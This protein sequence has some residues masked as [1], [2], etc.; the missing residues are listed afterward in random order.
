MAERILHVIG[1]MDRGGAE[2]FIMNLYRAVDRERI[3]FDFLVHEQ[4]LC[5]YDEEISDLGGRLYRLPRYNGLNYGAYRSQC[6]AFFARVSE[7]AVVHGHIGS[8]A[9]IY[10]SEARRAGRYTIAHSHAQNYEPGLSGLAFRIASAPVKNI[11]DYFMACSREAGVD[12]FGERIV[13][14]GRFRI[15]P[16]GVDLEALRFDADERSRMRKELGLG[17]EPVFGHV[18]RLTEVKNHAFLLQVFSQVKKMLPNALLLLAGRGPLEVELRQA[19]ASSG[20]ADSVRFLGV[21]DDVGSLLQAMDVLVFPSLKE[22]LPVAVVEAQASGLPCALSTGIPEMAAA[23]STCKRLPLAAG[24]DAWAAECIELYEAADRE[25][26]EVVSNEMRS[27]D[28]DIRELARSLS[29]F[30]LLHADPSF[31]RV[32]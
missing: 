12:R 7:H 17:D 11:A 14:G 20:L 1:A 8:S 3:Q 4:R 13:E 21:R 16:N 27:S 23:T 9:P 22:G 19:A 26:R 2:T 18:G 10:L 32:P 6:R 28:F 5:D 15:V 31:R 30:Y 29:E 24:A 25:S